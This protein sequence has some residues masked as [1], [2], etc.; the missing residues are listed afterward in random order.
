MPRPSTPLISRKATIEAALS[1]IDDDGPDALSLPRLARELKVKPP[2]LYYH[3][4]DKEEILTAV[5]RAIV[6]KTVIPRRPAS[7][8]WSEWLTRLSLNFRSAVLRHRRAAPILLRYLPRDYLTNM[9]EDVAKY[10]A[11]CGVPLELH[12]QILDGMEKLALGATIVEAMQPAP[13]TRAQFAHADPESHPVLSAAD[14]ANQLNARQLFEHTVRSYLLGIAHFGS[15][16]TSRSG[17]LPDRLDV[18]A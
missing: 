6:T 7:G 5:A 8:D 11:E 15:I 4:A 14:R 16:G 17:E 1:I 13:R 2:S 12:V 3:F 18:S 9:Y 10:L